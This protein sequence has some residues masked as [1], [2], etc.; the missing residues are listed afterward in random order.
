MLS[1]L[2]VPIPDQTYFVDDAIFL[3]VAAKCHSFAPIFGCVLYQYDVQL[4]E[5][6][7]VHIHLTHPYSIPDNLFSSP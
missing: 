7:L 3:P 5:A 6:I 2:F 4:Q 1:P